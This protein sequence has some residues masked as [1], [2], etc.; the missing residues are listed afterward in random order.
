M[1]KAKSV[2]GRTADRRHPRID[3]DEFSAGVAAPPQIIGSDRRA[4]CNIRACHKDDLCF[5][6]IAPWKGTAVDAKGQLVSRG[7]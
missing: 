3:N 6:N 5:R 2:P 7:R 1:Y 4:F